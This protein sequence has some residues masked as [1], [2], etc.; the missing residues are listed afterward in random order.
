MV[1]PA[2]TIVTA[3]RLLVSK[4]QQLV[5]IDASTY[6][7]LQTGIE[8][9]LALDADVAEAVSTFL[10][11]ALQGLTAYGDAEKVAD[12]LLAEMPSEV[13]E[14]LGKDEHGEVRKALKFYLEESVKRPSFKAHTGVQSAQKNVAQT[15]CKCG[16][17]SILDSSIPAMIIPPF[18]FT[19]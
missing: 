5:D 7:D 13:V 6:G 16:E 15:F 8:D 19:T 18:Y 17:R 11:T 10:G 12:G 1:L 2:D 9:S 14:I 3:L 4:T